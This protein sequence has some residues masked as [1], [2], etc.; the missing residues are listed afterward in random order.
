MIRIISITS[1]TR[2]PLLRPFFDCT[3]Y[4]AD[5]FLV[6]FYF[7]LWTWLFHLQFAKVHLNM[8][9]FVVYSRDIN[10]NQMYFLSYHICCPIVA[11][12]VFNINYDKQCTLTKFIWN[13]YL[14]NLNLFQSPH[15]PPG[16]TVTNRTPILRFR[17]SPCRVLW[18]TL[19]VLTTNASV[20]LIRSSLGLKLKL[21]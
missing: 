5:T 12:T 2:R 18:T 3:M 14:I 13:W 20:V 4:I 17:P 10:H 1:Y 11:K 21:C 16:W 15:V 19:T 9:V 7:S 8:F 6:V